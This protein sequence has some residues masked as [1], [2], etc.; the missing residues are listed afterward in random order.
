MET[1]DHT[2]G[3]TSTGEHRCVRHQSSALS[4]HRALERL[5]LFRGELQKIVI[6][7][8]A[9]A[10]PRPRHAFSRRLRPFLS[11]WFPRSTETRVSCFFFAPP[12]GWQGR[13]HP[14]RTILGARACR[15]RNSSRIA[16]SIALGCGCGG[17]ASVL[18]CPGIGD[19]TTLCRSLPRG[20]SGTL[21]LK[22]G[23]F[24]RGEGNSH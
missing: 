22:R 11:Q 3:P 15:Y 8:S 17:M 12:K 9:D 18:V 21:A 24:C 1:E 4:S 2:R 14:G 7:C 10:R 23:K 16:L 20:L 5:P 13:Q 19:A 6:P